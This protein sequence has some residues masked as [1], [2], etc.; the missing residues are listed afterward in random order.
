MER[1]IAYVDGNELNAALRAKGWERFSWL[2]VSGLARRFLAPGQELVMTRYFVSLVDEPEAE[3]RRQA[4]YL[5]TLQTLPGLRAFCSQ[6]PA[7]TTSVRQYGLEAALEVKRV[8]AVEIA[9]E[10]MLDAALDRM[11]AVMLCSTD[12]SL[13]AVLSTARRLERH[14]PITVVFPPGQRSPALEQSASNVLH[15]GY[16]DLAESQ[17]QDRI[18]K[19]KGVVLRKPE[20]RR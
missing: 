5:E 15:I 14:R 11:D 17:L 19:D 2:D 12:G 20:A 1:V 13:A 10:M 7:E 8:P 16:H 18:A 6:Q 4:I 9:V 3:R